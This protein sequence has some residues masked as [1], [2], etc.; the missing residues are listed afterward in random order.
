MYL[1]CD[2]FSSMCFKK[3]NSFVLGNEQH[4][5]YYYYHLHFMDKETESTEMLINCPKSP[6]KVK[7]N[8]SKSLSRAFLGMKCILAE[9]LPFVF[10]IFSIHIVQE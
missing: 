4:L 3:S 9:S 10:I 6:S 1:L 2:K 8:E 5:W 7:I